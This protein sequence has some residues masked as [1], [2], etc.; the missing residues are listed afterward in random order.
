MF[1]AFTLTNVD[2]STFMFD[3]LSKCGI[4]QSYFVTNWNWDE[5]IKQHPLGLLI[6]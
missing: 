5:N 6:N 2:V 4:L 1:P 3:F